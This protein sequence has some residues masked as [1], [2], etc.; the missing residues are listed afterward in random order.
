MYVTLRV[1]QVIIS[2]F[3]VAIQ[4]KNNPI[5]NKNDLPLLVARIVCFFRLYVASVAQVV[6]KSR[7]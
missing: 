5:A 1:Q 7:Q 3:A 6:A 4:Y 2:K